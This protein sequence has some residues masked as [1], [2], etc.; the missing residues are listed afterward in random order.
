MSDDVER[1][2]KETVM[3]YIKVLYQSLLGGAE[4]NLE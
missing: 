4:E 2:W 3:M 1:I